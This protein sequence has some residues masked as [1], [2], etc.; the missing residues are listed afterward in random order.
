MGGASS[1]QKGCFS[2]VSRHEIIVSGQKRA[3]GSQ[4]RTKCA[5]MQHGAIKTG[6]PSIHPAIVE[7]P[8]GD[9]APGEYGAVFDRQKLERGL[10]DA[11]E[12]TF[13]MRLESRS[14]SIGEIEA[15]NGRQ[16]AFKKL[17]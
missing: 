12:R 8:Q 6:I 4:R 16:G 7:M 1:L 2:A 10:V 13:K 15:I 5:L 11:F 3:A 9:G 17:C 14:F